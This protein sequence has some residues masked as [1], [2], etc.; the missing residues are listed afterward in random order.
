MVR[1]VGTE[2]AHEASCPCDG[3]TVSELSIPPSTTFVSVTKTASMQLFWF[4]RVGYS[5]T[6]RLTFNFDLHGGK[7]LSSLSGSYERNALRD[8]TYQNQ[9]A[10]YSD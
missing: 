3:N 5:N 2:I 10:N 1:G 7:T 6:D 4:N 8:Q 9:Y